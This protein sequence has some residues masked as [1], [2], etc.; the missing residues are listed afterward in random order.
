WGMAVAGAL[1]LFLSIVLHELAHSLVGVKHQI[2][3]KGITLFVFCGVAEMSDEPPNAAA[4]LK[5]AAAGPRTSIGL[6]LVFLGLS[7]I[8]QG[9]GAP[10]VVSGALFYLA[11]INGLLALFNLVPAFPLDG[12]RILRA[13]LWY[14][15]GD[16]LV[17]TH[18]ASNLGAGFSFL[19]M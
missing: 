13:M 10:V 16:L 1:G 9:A 11:W 5:M 3:M 4:E 2:P 18:W 12:G 19:L 8:S 6:G 17:A 7:S 14:I 15:R